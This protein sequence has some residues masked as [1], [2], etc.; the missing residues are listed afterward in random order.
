MDY[1]AAEGAY[2]RTL[3][4]LT[5]R[6]LAEAFSSCGQRSRF[7]RAACAKGEA[8]DA[9]MLEVLREAA[10]RE[11]AASY[12]SARLGGPRWKLRHSLARLESQG[13]VI[14]KGATSDTT[15][16]AAG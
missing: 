12:L 16:R 3:G 14:R 8:F 6:E 2:A 9:F 5:L 10:P 7:A 4:E 1:I 15:Y 13:L 11:V